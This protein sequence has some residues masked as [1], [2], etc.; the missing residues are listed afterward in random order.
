[1]GRVLSLA[2]QLPHIPIDLSL[3]NHDK[4]RGLHLPV[5]MTIK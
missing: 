5:K 2:E 3:Q 1:M 4:M